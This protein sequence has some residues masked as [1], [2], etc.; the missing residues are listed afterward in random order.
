MFRRMAQKTL[1]FIRHNLPAHS[2]P[3]RRA[4]ALDA[5][6]SWDFPAIADQLG[7]DPALQLRLLG[8]YGHAASDLLSAAGTDELAPICSTPTLW[9]ELRWA[10]RA[11][12]VVHLEDLLLRRTRLGLLLPVGGLAEF[13]HIR[14]VCQPEL[15]WS[16]QH[17][18]AEANNY[19]ALWQRSYSPPGAEYSPL[20]AGI[21]MACPTLEA[22]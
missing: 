9:A 20:S 15:G 22:R 4:R 6:Q 14:A 10:A 17:W 5:I 12:Q 7:L 16:D 21:P 11:E 18:Q 2:R 13:D 1:N 3:D 19:W 8:R